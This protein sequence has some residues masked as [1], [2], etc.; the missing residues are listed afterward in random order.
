MCLV[1]LILKYALWNFHFCSV[2][3]T[4]IIWVLRGMVFD[5]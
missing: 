5:S 1:C 3:G 2:I 4:L